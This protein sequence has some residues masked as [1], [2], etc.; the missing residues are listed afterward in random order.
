MP[1]L[2]L[3]LLLQLSSR[4]CSAPTSSYTCAVAAAVLT[5]VQG[6]NLV[7]PL[8]NWD[9]CKLP[10]ELRKVGGGG[11][12]VYSEVSVVGWAVVSACR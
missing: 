2:L 7:M 10:K 3:L 4:T 8:R 11:T 1:M 6:T 9:E 12:R 5:H